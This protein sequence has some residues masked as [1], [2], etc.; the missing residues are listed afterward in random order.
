MLDLLLG[1]SPG[2]FFGVTVVLTGFAAYMTGQ[3][4]ANTWKPYVQVLI[5]CALLALVARFLIYGLFNGPLWSLPAYLFA[6]LVLMIIGSF[7]FRLTRARRMVRQYPWLY[8]RAGPFGW[9]RLGDG[10]GDAVSRT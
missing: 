1:T 2:V 7:G 5:Y 8:R 10:D 9:Q 3:A 6:T 4:V